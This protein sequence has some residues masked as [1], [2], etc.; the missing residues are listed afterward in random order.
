MEAHGIAVGVDVGCVS[1]RVRACVRACACVQ[2][3]CRGAGQAESQVCVCVCACVR[4]AGVASVDA[5]ACTC[6]HEPSGE[7]LAPKKHEC[8]VCTRVLIK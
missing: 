6:Q 7:A 5:R 2:E 8:C 3:G 4:C 1:V